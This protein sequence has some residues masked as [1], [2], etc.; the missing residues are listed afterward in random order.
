MHLH[1]INLISA[2]VI[3]GVIS[4]MAMLRSDRAKSL[5]YS[6]PIPIT[7]ALLATGS[8]ING[9]TFVGIVLANLFLWGTYYLYEVLK[10][11]ILLADTLLAFAYV[12]VGYLL[13]KVMTIPVSLGLTI[14]PV[15]WLILMFV[16]VK[17]PAMRRVPDTAQLPIWIKA[18]I[19]LSV[20]YLLFT[21]KDYLPGVIALFP[22]TGVFAVYEGKDLLKILALVFT[23]NSIAIWAFLAADHLLIVVMGKW[24][25]L[26]AS[27]I[28]YS[29]VL[30]AAIRV[31]PLKRQLS[32]QVLA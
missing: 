32:P 16:A 20:A 25:G 10:L 30:L 18:P 15:L 5:V 23:R 9:L 21:A 13:S 4:L 17:Q 8:H 28:V 14:F 19:V 24:P 11:P 2:L 12:V 31:F 7:V 3:C 29:M 22:F 27:W 1:A 6:L 26:L